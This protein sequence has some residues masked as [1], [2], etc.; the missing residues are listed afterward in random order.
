MRQAMPAGAKLFW[1]SLLAKPQRTS[2]STEG[3]FSSALAMMPDFSIRHILA[4]N[5]PSA[6]LVSIP[7][8]HASVTL[9]TLHRTMPGRAGAG[10]SL[11]WA[12]KRRCCRLRAEDSGVAMTKG[13]ARPQGGR[14]L[15]SFARQRPGPAAWLADK[16]LLLCATRI[17]ALQAMML[18]GPP[19]AG[20]VADLARWYYASRLAVAVPMGWHQ[21]GRP[22]ARSFCASLRHLPQLEEQR[23]GACADY[24]P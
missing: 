13:R 15:L 2:H 17:G 21:P 3:G 20:S 23:T 5:R 24:S 8:L 14:D 19:F 10:L 16:R 11:V 18:A 1:T 4:A 6:T 7:I 12:R 9:V 22:G